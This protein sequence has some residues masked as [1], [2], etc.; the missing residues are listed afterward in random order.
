MYVV[1]VEKYFPVN[2]TIDIW[3]LSE[4]RRPRLSLIFYHLLYKTCVVNKLVITTSEKTVLSIILKIEN[5]ES[6]VDNL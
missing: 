1:K 2:P 6:E 5:R 4:I 3:D